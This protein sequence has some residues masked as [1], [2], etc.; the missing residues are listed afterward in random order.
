MRTLHYVRTYIDDL[1]IISSGTFDDHLTKLHVV[2]GRLQKAGLRINATKSN[3]CQHEI[4]YLGYVL[5]REA[6]ALS[7]KKYRLF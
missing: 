5:T 3:F 1:L 7:Q 2:L 4:E 6:F